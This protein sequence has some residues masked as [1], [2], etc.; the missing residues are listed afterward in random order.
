VSVVGAYG[1]AVG[2][3]DTLRGDARGGNDIVSGA[4]A[5]GESIL[6]YDNAVGGNDKVTVLKSFGVGDAVVMFGDSRGGNDIVVGTA[7][8]ARLYGDAK[9]AA[10]TS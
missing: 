4:Y 10:M 6:M 5:F 2:D 7:D 3:A 9:L 8:G 1:N